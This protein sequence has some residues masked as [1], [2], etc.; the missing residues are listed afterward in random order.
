MA[1]VK[2][3][4][5][6]LTVIGVSVVDLSGVGIPSGLSDKYANGGRSDA[7]PPASNRGQLT[8]TAPAAGVSFP[9]WPAVARA[10]VFAK[11]R[12]SGPH[13]A[14][15]RARTPLRIRTWTPP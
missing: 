4:T 12:A 2:C 15:T 9:T 8:L 11:P 1:S 13:G 3:G 7:L 6:R 14:G 5:V 10:A